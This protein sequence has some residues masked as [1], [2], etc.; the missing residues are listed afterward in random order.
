MGKERGKQ[1]VKRLDTIEIAAKQRHLHLLGKVQGNQALTK[2]EL[3]ELAEY[4]KVTKA[5]K[6]GNGSDKDDMLIKTQV[7]AARFAGVDTRTIRRW[8]GN[9]MPVTP[10]GWYIR[11]VLQ[12]FRDNEG[13]QLSKARQRG[14]EADAEYKEK[15][16]E[17]IKH[18]LGE[19]EKEIN[20]IWERAILLKIAAVKRALLGHPRKMAPILEDKKRQEIQKLLDVEVRYMIGIFSGQNDG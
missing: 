1:P 16:V 3:D 9:G 14:D 18:E 6:N 4:E 13:R 11:Q 8:K 12:Y 20:A 5:A 15:R 19:R 2:T 17:L 10:Q 7:E